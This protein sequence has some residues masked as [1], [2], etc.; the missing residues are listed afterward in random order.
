MYIFNLVCLMC[1]TLNITEQHIG[2]FIY[3]ILL[4]MLFVYVA[5]QSNGKI[6]SQKCYRDGKIY[7]GLILIDEKTF[8]KFEH[9]L[10]KITQSIS[11]GDKLQFDSPIFERNQNPLTN[12]EIKLAIKSTDNF[13]LIKSDQTDDLKIKIND[14]NSS[15]PLTV[16]ATLGLL[17][18]GI[19]WAQI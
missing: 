1:Y 12:S 6:H 14:Y 2:C 4:L 5:Y 3:G 10:F 16:T 13:V 11:S 17:H 15:N 8:K 9:K 19:F 18:F 7:Y